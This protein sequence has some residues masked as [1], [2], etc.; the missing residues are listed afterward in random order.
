[1]KQPKI[2]EKEI[3]HSIRSLLKQFGIF[4]WKNFGGPMGEKG[5]PDILGILKDGR[6]LGIEVKTATG[7]LSPHQEKFIQSI[8][9]TGGVA[10]VARSVDDVVDKLG[11]QKRMLF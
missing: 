2:S 8:N 3:T 6:F 4:H 5:V 7:K 1:M 9:N 10:F 11:L